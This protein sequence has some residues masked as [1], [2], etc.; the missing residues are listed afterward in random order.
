MQQIINITDVRNNLSRLV[1]EVASEDKTIVIIR[2]SRPEAAIISYKKA[3]AIDD[4]LEKK[5]G[6]E[7]KKILAAGKKF[8]RAWAK[9]RG[10]DLKKIT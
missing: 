4:E 2:D 1:K 8:G 3:R 5:R 6:K 9:K 10:I 7:F